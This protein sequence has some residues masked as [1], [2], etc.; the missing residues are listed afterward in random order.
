MRELM[1]T[2][3]PPIA[4]ALALSTG[5]DTKPAPKP[6]DAAAKSPSTESETEFPPVADGWGYRE[7]AQV[8]NVLL[9]LDKTQ[10]ELLVK[11]ADPKGDVLA[12]VASPEFIG[13]A[14]AK[15]PDM[16]TIHAFAEPITAIYKLY[17]TRVFAG[18]PY[19]AEYLLLTRTLIRS[20][21]A[22]FIRGVSAVGGEAKLH[23][24]IVGRSDLMSMRTGMYLAYLSALTAPLQVPGTVDA[25]AAMPELAAAAEDVAPFLVP[26]ERA[27][28][29]QILFMLT[30]L[31]AD[32]AQVASTRAAIHGAPLHPL[33]AAFVSE[34]RLDDEQQR[35]LERILD[36]DY[37]TLLGEP[38]SG[39][40]RYVFTDA[41]FSAVFQ[42]EPHAI[43]TT[44]N[45]KD[46]VTLTTRML[47]TR[48]EAGHGTAIVCISRSVPPPKATEI[49]EVDTDGHNGFEAAFSNSNS[50]GFIQTF[51]LERGGCM[52][53][54][55][56]P[57]Q[58]ADGYKKQA[59]VFLRSVEFDEFE[60]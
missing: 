57:P 41:G 58:L 33:V 31:G 13:K 60:G 52:I 6:D 51:D 32:P 27:L 28:I 44:S 40:I 25:H 11:L 47:G 59:R 38:E 24:D 2:Y 45:A 39:G 14:I 43:L 23:D 53:I 8:R 55:E 3:V 30:A 16:D 29:D 36:Q 10:P 9:E 5:C 21:A 35:N 26:E 18:Q 34:A 22:Q 20:A 19:G 49:L 54:V 17:A 1:S 42:Q 37:N 12:R 15:A 48:D 4:L 46:G 7:Y 50:R 56:S